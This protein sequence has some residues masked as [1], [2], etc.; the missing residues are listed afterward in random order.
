MQWTPGKHLHM[1]DTLSRAYLQQDDVCTMDEIEEHVAGMK[2]QMP[3][4]SEMWQKISKETEQ[5]PELSKLKKQI[6]TGW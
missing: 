5:D 4:S 1:P 6:L 2:A 3:V